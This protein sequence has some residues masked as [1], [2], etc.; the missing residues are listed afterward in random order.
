MR[1]KELSL[2]KSGYILVWMLLA[3]LMSLTVACSSSKKVENTAL[4]TG[5]D[6]TLLEKAVDWGND[7]LFEET[8]EYDLFTLQTKMSGDKEYNF[9]FEQAA[10]FWDCALYH[11]Q[12]DEQGNVTKVTACGSGNAELFSYDIVKLSGENYA[13]VY[14][15]SH[16]GN[17][18]L[19]LFPLDGEADK[20]YTIDGAVDRHYEAMALVNEDGYDYMKSRIYYDGRLTAEYTDVNQDG[21]TDIVLRGII[22]TY[23]G[24][25]EEEY[26]NSYGELTTSQNCTRTY[27]YHDSTK[28]YE[29][30]EEELVNICQDDGSDY[31]YTGYLD[32]HP[33][34]AEGN[35]RAD[36]DGDGL[37]DRVY[38]QYDSDTQEASFYLYFGSGTKLL[39]TD[40][41]QGIFFKTET[42]ELTGD[43]E[44]EIL[45][46][47]FSTS[48]KCVN[49][50]LSVYTKKNGIY[51]RMEI[52]YYG[53]P[54]VNGRVDGMLYLPLIM[55]KAGDSRV[56]VYQPDSGYETLITT[57]I[58]TY[59]SGETD[60]EMEHLYY[61][62]TEGILQ[63]YQASEMQL[64]DT[65]EGNKKAFLLRSYLGDKWCAKSVSWK[66]EYNEGQWKIT[67]MYTADP[68]RMEIGEEACL[69][70]DGDKLADTVTYR[71]E[72]YQN[73]DNGFDYQVPNLMINGTEYDYQ[74]LEDKFGVSLADCS[75]IGYYILD[76]VAG[77]SCRELAILDEGLSSDPVTYIFRYTGKELLYCGSVT[78]FPSNTAFSTDG[79]GNITAS[80]RLHILQTWWTS[81]VWK[82]NDEDYL[83]EEPRDF[84]YTYYKGLGD[85]IN[86]AQKELELFQKPDK[87]SGSVMVKKGEALILTATDDKNWIEVTTENGTVG[88]FYLHDGYEVTL[89]AGEANLSD[90]L[91]Y[92]NM[93]D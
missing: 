47:Q 67:D 70:L 45:F 8:K 76:L 20:T 79:N 36:Y 88:W 61:P 80:K 82:L 68:V 86:Y 49:L 89:P 1:R 26:A 16:M 7:S 44:K 17:G 2:R 48:T 14:S 81:A 64:A 57:E 27:L 11:I 53:E 42:A 5:E 12:C 75:R 21:Y 28:E 87:N 30:W 4:I 78:G 38:R 91:L 6:K 92:L 55:K 29:L 93:A 34:Y 41:G 73:N 51:E 59:D 24:Y 90:I 66:L 33:R 50:Y 37:L 40:A 46:E 35:P 3:V 25:P 62:N 84:Y 54:D 19:M 77:D 52:P 22:L 58:Y 56:S 60:N 15:A 9:L 32:I 39:L 69:D 63:S 31:E 10:G 83:E 72:T 18:C 85:H 13:A 71:I 43:G 23:T 65:G 74:Y